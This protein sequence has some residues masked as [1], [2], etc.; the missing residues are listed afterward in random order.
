MITALQ[1]AF[2]KLNSDVSLK[3]DGYYIAEKV[4]YIADIDYTYDAQ[5]NVVSTSHI[6]K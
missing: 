1:A 2:T 3:D 6:N 4:H 5:G